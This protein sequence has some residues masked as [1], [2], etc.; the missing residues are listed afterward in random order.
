[1]AAI[2][3]LVALIIIALALL[4]LIIH[5]LVLQ[6]Q[7]DASLLRLTALILM[8]YRLQKISTC[9]KRNSTGNDDSDWFE[10][11]QGWLEKPAQAGH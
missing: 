5:V 9:Q 3:I 2:A 11:F 1:V 7:M 8:Y 6:S 10:W 4:A